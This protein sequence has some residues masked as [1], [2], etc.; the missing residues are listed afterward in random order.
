MPEQR[1]QRD[2]GRQGRKR[3]ATLRRRPQRKRP[4]RLAEGPAVSATPGGPAP[5]QQGAAERVAAR[6][7]ARQEESPLR[8]AL[9]RVWLWVRLT[10]I[11]LFVLLVVAL[12]LFYR[13]VSEVADAIVVQDVR[14]NPSV[15]T[16]LL[17]GVNVLLIG[18]DE[19]PDHPEEGVRSD[20]LIVA[21]LDG[22]GGWV[23]LLSIPR[24]TQTNVLDVGPTKI[25][26]AYGQGYAR[27]TS[28][29]W[30]DTTPQQGGMALAA[31]TVEGFFSTAANRH[32]RVD[33][34]AQIN[35]DG[36]VQVIDALGG[37]TIDVP[38][39]IVDEAYPTANYGIMR[40]EFQPGPQR[41][42]GETALIY[43][44]TR[45]ADSDFGRAQRQ[46]QVLRAIVAELDNRG[47]LGRVAALPALLKS[48]KGSEGSPPPVLTT[49]PIDRFDVL[50]GLVLLVRGLGPDSI[51]QIPINPQTVPMTEVGTNLLWDT[52][53]LGN[54]VDKLTQPPMVEVFPVEE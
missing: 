4:P 48:I 33:Y 13:Q 23:N 22:P 15:A 29:Y 36:F 24:D 16:P 46:Q 18:V 49:L 30:E 5:L 38:K 12:V 6:R 53:S 39:P 3:R 27:A 45:H 44:R 51:G 2:I 7:A 19:R 9:R 28:L 8:Q 41:M 47:W 31:E 21:R 42:D 26:V 54:Q 14:T 25:N 20:T 11:A 52:G 35:F 32:V 50:F 43:A 17:G 10:G 37:I 40:V 34:T 1:N